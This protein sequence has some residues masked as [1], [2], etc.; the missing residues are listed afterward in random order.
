MG[1]GSKSPRLG[2]G[3]VLHVDSGRWQ[4]YAQPMIGGLL[5]FM[6]KLISANLNYVMGGDSTDVLKD[7]VEVSFK[8]GLA[9]F[10][11]VYE[12]FN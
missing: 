9:Q 7:G 10:I 6:L 5:N 3:S 2:V 4:R 1:G 8:W 12:D 11:V